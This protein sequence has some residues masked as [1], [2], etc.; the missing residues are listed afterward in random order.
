MKVAVIV[1][2]LRGRPPTNTKRCWSTD[3]D[4]ANR[5]IGIYPLSVR[6]GPI[7]AHNPTPDR[8]NQGP[9]SGGVGVRSGAAQ[10]GGPDPS[11]V[12]CSSATHRLWTPERSASPATSGQE[13]EAA[14]PPSAV[15]VGQTGVTHPL[16]LGS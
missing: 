4:I 14:P 2:P 10:T 6:R 15:H 7:E 16:G 8:M 13:G 9:S 12:G 3:A 1:V 5:T 11:M